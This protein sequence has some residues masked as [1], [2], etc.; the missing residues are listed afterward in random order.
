MIEAITGFPGAGKTLY[1]MRSMIKDRKKGIYDKIL[2]IDNEVI[3]ITNFPVNE[4]LLPNTIVIGNDEISKLYDWIL[5][6]KYFGA[7][8]YIDEASI[9]FPALAYK[10]I[11]ND[12]IIALRQHRH[13]GYTLR[14]TAQDLD[15]VAAGLRRVTQFTTEVKGYGSLPF[16]SFSCYSVKKG[17]PNYKDR[18]ERGFYRHTKTLYNSYDTHNNIE[19]PDYIGIR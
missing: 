16:S 2:R 11:P 6:K 10:N 15:D 4:E 1:M 3:Q 9:I 14:Y 17:K 7:Y 13:A 19:T 18:Y 12:V 5:N 8:I